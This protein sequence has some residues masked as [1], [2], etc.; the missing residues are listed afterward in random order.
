ML[1]GETSIVSPNQM[2]ASTG[3]RLNRSCPSERQ[4]VSEAKVFQRRFLS[5][6]LGL[7]NI[8]DVVCHINTRGRVHVINCRNDI[9]ITGR[10]DV[11]RRCLP[12]TLRSET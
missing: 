3:G 2:G 7:F 9:T 11:K 1:I 6:F 5:L 12:G 10:R 8:H 4:C